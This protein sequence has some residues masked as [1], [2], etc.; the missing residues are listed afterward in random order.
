MS[1]HYISLKYAGNVPERPQNGWRDQKMVCQF[2]NF[3]QNSTQSCFTI[4]FYMDTC[5]DDAWRLLL[6]LG[7][8]LR[9]RSIINMLS[10][11]GFPD[12]QQ[13]RASS[14]VDAFTLGLKRFYY[15][16][17]KDKFEIISWKNYWFLL[18]K[19]LFY[20]ADVQNLVSNNDQLM[21]ASSFWQKEKNKSYKQ[22][23]YLSYSKTQDT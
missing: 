15:E 14:C 22:L 9:F 1:Y 13:L 8:G 3:G 11:S 19:M 12:C 2:R 6:H 20:C 21:I 23:Y 4:I 5:L 10:G 17:K 16:K 18:R 7:S